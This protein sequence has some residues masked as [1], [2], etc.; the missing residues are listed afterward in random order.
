MVS[1]RTRG[2][3]LIRLILLVV[4]LLL[5]GGAF[6]LAHGF[7]VRRHAGTLL[8]HADRF[9][10]D[11]DR[12]KVA[13]YLARY[14]ILAPEDTA[15]AGRLAM[16][17][18]EDADTPREKFDAARRCDQVLRRDSSRNDI[19]RYLVQLWLDIGRY[20][21]AVERADELREANLDSAD[22]WRLV[23]KAYRAQAK[24][25]ESAQA[26]EQ[27]LALGGNDV[28][29]YAELA[30][31]YRERLS[32]TKRAD[33]LMEEMVAQHPDS[34]RAYEIRYLYNRR[35]G[36]ED[37]AADDVQKAL[38]L[39]PTDATALLTA[40]DLAIRDRDLPKAVEYAEQGM[41]EHPQNPRF[42][43]VL[44]R[45]HV[46]QGDRE[47]AE[48]V[49]RGGLE[50]VP[51][52]PDLSWWLADLLIQKNKL[53]EAEKLLTHLKEV[54]SRSPYV[55]YLEARFLQSKGDAIR[56][57]DILEQVAARAGTI[58][59][60]GT[61][62][63]FYLGECYRV[64]DQPD[65]ALAAYRRAIQ[66]EPYWVSPRLQVAQLLERRGQMQ[67]AISEYDKIIAL[68]KVPPEVLIGLA[69]A[70]LV[71]QM[72]Q[73]AP[74]RKW[75]GFNSA[76]EQLA[77]K[78]PE[79]PEYDL[80]QAEYLTVMDR[81]DEAVQLLEKAVVDHRDNRSVWLALAT[82]Y[83]RAR[84]PE[85][86]EETLT[87]ATRELGD[88]PLLRRARA[89][90]LLLQGNYDEARAMLEDGL[91]DR[92]EEDRA[93][94][95]DGLVELT[96]LKPD[97]AAASAY[98]EQ[99]ALVRP[100]D[101]NVHMMRLDLAFATAD[102]EAIAR[103]L[104]EF[105]ELPAGLKSLAEYAEA[106]RL[107]QSGRGNQKDLEES[108]RILSELR[109]RRPQW[110][111]VHALIGQVEEL[112]G[113]ADAAI[114]SYARAQELGDMTPA[115]AYRLVQL[116]SSRGRYNEANAVFERLG[117]SSSLAGNLSRQVTIA[118]LRAG[119]SDQAVTL[120]RQL[121]AAQPENFRS[122]LWLG[123]VLVSAKQQDEAEQ[124]F[125]Q[126]LSLNQ[127]APEA[128]A[129]LIQFYGNSA[130][131]DEAKQALEEAKGQLKPEDQVLA[132]PQF[133][134]VLGMMEEAEEG[135]RRALADQPDNV[136][137]QGV[138][139]NYFLRRGNVPDAEA[140]LR[141]ILTLNPE[142]RSTRRGLAVLI[143]TRRGYPAWQEAR[144]LIESN[145]EG[146]QATPQDKRT[147]V[148][149]LSMRPSPANIAEAIKL[150]EEMTA[151]EGRQASDS[152]LLAD[153]CFRHGERDKGRRLLQNLI[154]EGDLHPV[155]I[156]AA[157]QVLLREGELDDAEA[158]LKKLE[159]AVPNSRTA[160]YGRARMLHERNVPN[161]AVTLL[162]DL[163]R[164]AKEPSQKQQLVR[165]IASILDTFKRST[166]VETLY[167]ELARDEKALLPAL[168]MW[169]ARNGQTDGA[170]RACEQ[171][172]KD[173]P[174]AAALQGLSILMLSDATPDQIR[175]VEDWHKQA[176]EKA[177]AEKKSEL[178][179][180]LSRA[181]LRHVQGRNDES[182]RAFRDL[183]AQ[184]ANQLV[185]LNNL[186]WVLCEG[187][188][189]PAE[190]LP[191]IEQ[192]VGQ[193]GPVPQLLDTRGVILTRMGRYDEAVADL[194][195]SA[196]ARSA[197]SSSGYIH[198]ARAYLLAGNREAAR[199]ALA[200]VQSDP[201]LRKSQR[202]EYA[203]LRSELG[204]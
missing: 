48:Q 165:E 40:A 185:G 133:Y 193:F 200:K 26:Y 59:E 81:V 191:F 143:A 144:T 17:L 155:N 23:A 158:W 24:Y 91:S 111:P 5:A 61:Q 58:L 160:V 118:S 140:C 38:E 28:D 33:Q 124:A 69:R 198:V 42:P 138:A 60:L 128:W 177:L 107:A 182:V 35:F 163:L 178:D 36:K 194:L 170:L 164:T 146:S 190:A 77:E 101:L 65:L 78:G 184:G 204:N 113:N 66:A 114:E 137:A 25:R 117:R 9:E 130:K 86:A 103:M 181:L 85:R 88:Q 37:R 126:A 171:F 46:M 70:H 14:L 80:L 71:R 152:M 148:Q 120:A 132:V 73:P 100:G 7:Q 55:N 96:L 62:A 159:T 22:T 76:M 34:P 16:L 139:A 122:H 21:E 134:E 199:A 3:R 30:G 145:F 186:A 179:I 43:L 29:L 90:G 87:L 174:D 102:S 79:T 142:S 75:D 167:R 82:M 74:E 94:L 115:V 4:G 104:K 135:F 19:R 154:N 141:K 52:N 183:L 32:D 11:G 97:R 68:G 93:V 112:L 99:L 83:R 162:N 47:R 188:N 129:A 201:V 105:R 41:A 98:L 180:E 131:L 64:A 197:T 108:R 53:A 15:V 168:A 189:K 56:A 195:E 147:K 1:Q 153:L 161:R 89:G 2:L 187:M 95:L 50:K 54:A 92:S 175:M 109:N 31:L 121:V 106:R 169:L 172:A 166:Q 156:A 150:I 176:A 127:Q 84:Q 110:A 151:L 123:Q 20:A 12:E 149:I 136:L 27:S 203:R 119:E 8:G 173:R 202:A 63:R 51:D 157:T 44:A 13:Q 192:A 39:A 116:L 57:A 6:H 45:L 10:K 125:R 67:E 72:R 18:A 49:L 196:N